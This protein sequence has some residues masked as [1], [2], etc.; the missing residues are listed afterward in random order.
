LSLL[1][2]V[3]IS[4][5]LENRDCLC[6]TGF[7]PIISVYSLFWDVWSS[8]LW[9]LLF[10]CKMDRLLFLM[11]WVL[12]ILSLRCKLGFLVRFLCPELLLNWLSIDCCKFLT[13]FVS[14]CLFFLA[15]S[16]VVFLSRLDPNLFFFDISIFSS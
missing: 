14:S 8:L 7:I 15:C 9:L 16:L 3:L 2:R 4:W 12:F 1:F 11:V 13:V 10:L 5:V 6:L